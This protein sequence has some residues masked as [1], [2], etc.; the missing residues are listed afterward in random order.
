MFGE[1]EGVSQ[2]SSWL[3]RRCRACVEATAPEVEAIAAAF[4]RE[5]RGSRDLLA[6][7][8]RGFAEVFPDS[9]ELAIRWRRARC[10]E[11]EDA[12]GIVLGASRSRPMR[13]VAAALLGGPAVADPVVL[14]GGLAALV[15]EPEQPG[16]LVRALEDGAIE[17]VLASLLLLAEA[18]PSVPFAMV[19]DWEAIRRVAGGAPTRVVMAVREGMIDSREMERGGDHGEQRVSDGA[20]WERNLTQRKQRDYRDLRPRRRTR[21]ESPGMAGIPGGGSDG[22]ESGGEGEAGREGEARSVAER[23]LWRLLEEHSESR[24]LFR[25]NQRMPYRFGSRPAEIDLFAIS[26][27]LAIEVDGYYHFLDAEAYR[28]D[29]HKDVLL[30][31]RGHLV[32]RVLADDVFDRPADVLKFIIDA[33]RR[34]RLPP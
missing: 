17:P 9:G 34:R 28:R 14:F 8:A 22:G 27:G 12:V 3:R 30:Q 25:L 1:M 32:L 5:L 19:G 23:E 33:V 11:R 24:G 6:D 10:V 21:L 16:I 15:P 7:V 20:R 4:R 18:A 31:E 2:W 13:E 29:R 26:I